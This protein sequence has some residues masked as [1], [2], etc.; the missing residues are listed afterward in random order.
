MISRRQIVFALGA[1]ALAAPHALFAQTPKILRRIS[2]LSVG[3]IGSSGHLTEFRGALKELGWVEGR[4]TV[5]EVRYA[6]DQIKRLDTLAAELVSLKPDLIFAPSTQSAV[7]AQRATRDIPIVFALPLDPIGSGLIASFARPGGNITGLSTN[8]AELGPK[9]LQLFKECIPALS[10]AVVL[11]VPASGYKP[12]V[13]ETVLRAGKQLGLKMAV[14]GASTEA[15]IE[16][17]FGKL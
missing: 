13:L 8:A 2:I 4:D 5:I 11:H 6:N 7:A 12:E 14:L 9:R 17:A 16:A 3:T 15:E 10:R 1:V